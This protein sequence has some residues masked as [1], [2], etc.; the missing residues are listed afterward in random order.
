MSNFKAWLET[1]NNTKSPK[2]E[3][4]SA[5]RAY[6][7][8]A[9]VLMMW[10]GPYELPDGLNF[11]EHRAALTRIK[12]EAE[13][14]GFDPEGEVKRLKIDSEDNPKWWAKA[15]DQNA[16][17]DEAAPGKSADVPA[18]NTP[19]RKK[20]SGSKRRAVSDSRYLAAI[21][22]FLGE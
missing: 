14:A 5:L 9:F 18:V 12:W 11:K 17:W 2:G 13:R 19:D 7:H 10:L 22:Y 3:M 21:L 16:E 20:T 4:V 8:P 6:Q 1:R 15:T